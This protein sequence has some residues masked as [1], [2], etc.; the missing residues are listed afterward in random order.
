MRTFVDEQTLRNFKCL[1]MGNIEIFRSQLRTKVFTT[2]LSRGWNA[3]DKTRRERTTNHSE[4][5]GQ[6]SISVLYQ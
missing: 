6:L 4:T 5:N 3:F 1:A 2:V